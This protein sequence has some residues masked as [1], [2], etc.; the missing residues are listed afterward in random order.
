[1]STSGTPDT[2]GSL[3]SV[4]S[5]GSFSTPL[6]NTPAASTDTPLR[7]PVLNLEQLAER[8]NALPLEEFDNPIFSSADQPSPAADGTAA[9]PLPSPAV[10]LHSDV[11]ATP[12][13]PL[14]RTASYTWNFFNA[15]QW[16][17]PLAVDTV[18]YSED[19]SRAFVKLYGGTPGIEGLD[20][21]AEYEKH[22]RHFPP[23]TSC[24]AVRVRTEIAWLANSY[25]PHSPFQMWCEEKLFTVLANLDKAVRTGTQQEKS[26]AAEQAATALEAAIVDYK[27]EFCGSSSKDLATL[28]GTEFSQNASLVDII[29]IV[30]QCS[31]LY[32]IN[33]GR[34]PEE[35]GVVELLLERM[36]PT[37]STKVSLG[38]A[39][40]AGTEATR[41]TLANVGKILRNLLKSR[42]SVLF[43]QLGANNNHA[44]TNQLDDVHAAATSR[45][46]SSAN[47]ASF[48]SDVSSL[49]F[50]QASEVDKCRALAVINP[51][52]ICPVHKDGHM[53]KDCPHVLGTKPGR[54]KPRTTV[55]VNAAMLDASQ[56][57]A[58]PVASLSDQ[59]QHAL[60][61]AM[62]NAAQVFATHTAGGY[63][64]QPRQHYGQNSDRYPRQ[65]Q[66]SFRPQ[67]PPCEACGAPGH[68]TSACWVLRP[69]KCSDQSMLSQH[70]RNIP[71]EC[72]PL[73][74]ANLKKFNL[75]DI[76]APQLQQPAAGPDA[77]P[78]KAAHDGPRI[79]FT[80]TGGSTFA[81]PCSEQP[82][83]VVNSMLASTS[84]PSDCQQCAGCGHPCDVK[85]SLAHDTVGALTW[86]CPQQ[87]TSACVS[88]VP[89][90]TNDQVLH[91]CVARYAGQLPVSYTTSKTPD[92]ECMEV[93]TRGQAKSSAATPA[94]SVTAP[95]CSE[96]SKSST[97]T[98]HKQKPVSFAPAEPQKPSNAHTQQ[99]SSLGNGWVVLPMDAARSALPSLFSSSQSDVSTT[100]AAVFTGN[101]DVMFDAAATASCMAA[102]ARLLDN[103]TYR[104]KKGGVCK[105][106]QPLDRIEDCMMIAPLSRPSVRLALPDIVYADTC[107]DATFMRRSFAVQNGIECI[108]AVGSMTHMRT[109]GGMV[110]KPTTT[111]ELIHLVFRKGTPQEHR[112]ACNAIVVDDEALPY[113]IILGTPV[114]HVLA[115]SI[116][117]MTETMLVRP[118][119]FQHGDCNTQFTCPIV[120]TELSKSKPSPLLVEPSVAATHANV[121]DTPPAAA[122]LALSD[123]AFTT[124]ACTMSASQ[125]PEHLSDE[126][127]DFG[128]NDDAQ[129]GQEPASDTGMEEAAVADPVAGVPAPVDKP[130]AA[131]VGEPVA[132]TEP[133]MMV[134]DSTGQGHD[135]QGGDEGVA[136]AG[137]AAAD[138]AP[139]AAPRRSVRDRLSGVT[140]SYA[141]AAR[142]SVP[143]SFDDPI[144][145][146]QEMKAKFLDNLV[147]GGVSR[148]LATSAADAFGALARA[149]IL[150]AVSMF[151][152]ASAI[153][154]ILAN[155]SSSTSAF[156]VL[157][158]QQQLLLTGDRM[159]VSSL[160]GA[161]VTGDAQSRIVAALQDYGF[162]GCSNLELLQ[163]ARVHATGSP[164][165]SLGLTWGGTC[166]A[167][168]FIAHL[169]LHDCAPASARTD[170]PSACLTEAASE[171][172]EHLGR[173]LVSTSMIA[174]AQQQQQQLA[175]IAVPLDPAVIMQLQ[176]NPTELHAII[177]MQQQAAALLAQAQQRAALVLSAPDP[178]LPFFQP[179]PPPGP[180]P[181]QLAE[182]GGCGN[183]R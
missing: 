124:C 62:G 136:A 73:F 180:S 41:N 171:A 172:R 8:L 13:R 161:S 120:T 174:Q 77:Y 9:P 37:L 78:P 5:L 49:A 147:T 104:S 98:V 63:Q 168:G 142:S 106:L 141:D 7:T 20:H 152:F 39:A 2:S 82:D 71:D 27:K 163:M 144:G 17:D 149:T 54:A 123:L 132:V 130:P 110:S 90:S 121:T 66:Q 181:R 127:L 4:S 148:D 10:S 92:C 112:V 84:S 22:A 3:S 32:G 16:H 159:V 53:L 118:R 158:L 19:M 23:N 83:T 18:N 167:C 46:S 145:V 109:V 164:E 25:E 40:L 111:T 157:S 65:Q 176:G 165:P 140:R 24:P 99:Q 146:A 48:S 175:M 102:A 74:I 67:Y 156:Q 114:L 55:E 179:P 103:E 155:P 44:A 169:P 79:A 60:T 133:G 91:A 1:M 76:V 80:V 28:L 61:E 6:A 70:Y 129:E 43:L 107:S 96:P 38:L 115:C 69:D 52:G 75:Y 178:T 12:A 154:P 183:R 72:K 150:G 139:P 35:C 143:V 166:D 97:A 11:F 93:S 128:D 15:R 68:P 182:Q 30:N 101:H 26:D 94:S 36:P 58:D 59:L 170:G 14:R 33:A 116:D 88:G 56:S 51:Q 29:K 162:M 42:E 57:A 34:L 89:V 100:T 95:T 135:E 119:F 105:L 122:P 85:F 125:E 173:R 113:D 50:S 160:G 86:Q 131:V 151:R 87:S 45:S 117:F 137:A 64:Q 126:E 81:A 47:K 153:G 138:R 21:L 31:T 134:D 177:A 108:T